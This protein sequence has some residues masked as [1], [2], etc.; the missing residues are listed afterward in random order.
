MPRLTVLAAM[1][2]AGIALASC[3][4]APSDQ[5]RSA[6]VAGQGG[7]PAQALNQA[8]TSDTSLSNI[9]WRPTPIADPAFNIPAVWVRAPEG[10]TANG[11]VLHDNP[12][13]PGTIYA[14]RAASSDGRLSADM[15]IP[16]ATRWNWP[17]QREG[18]QVAPPMSAGDFLQ[19]IVLPR[20]HSGAQVVSLTVPPDAQA[21]SRNISE[22]NAESQR[23]GSSSVSGDSVMAR[24]RYTLNGAQVD[25]QITVLTWV[26]SFRDGSFLSTASVSDLRAPA[27]ELDRNL[28]LFGAIRTGIIENPQWWAAQQAAGQQQS[29]ANFQS[30]LNTARAQSAETQARSDAFHRQNQQ[31]ANHIGDQQSYTD[32]QT[33]RTTMLSNQYQNTYT[34]GQGQYVQGNQGFDPNANGGNQTWTPVQPGQ[35][36]Q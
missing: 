30:N 6:G 29:Q 12:C 5:S 13:M 32:P 26:T 1:M 24:V 31:F 4:G 35:G 27:G 28:P 3:G 22:L 11:T 14:V 19:R 8:P 15:F 36:A 20:L 16:F 23:E 33:G 25:G 21:H 17:I 34:N 18:C 9:I 7:D 10:W 2:L